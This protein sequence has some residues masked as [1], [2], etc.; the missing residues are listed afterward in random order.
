MFFGRN[1]LCIINPTLNISLTFNPF[2]AM[3]LCVEKMREACNVEQT[4]SFEIKQIDVI[5]QQIGVVGSNLWENKDISGI[6]DYKAIEKKMDWS[7][8]TPYK[9]TIK[10]I[11]E[12]DELNKLRIELNL[13]QDLVQSLDL[14]T[15]RNYKLK[16]IND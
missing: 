14:P 7:Y 5:P 12:K 10:R 4:E 15:E 3:G 1:R 9:G 11:S 13:G 16:Y 2:D 8:S 6:K